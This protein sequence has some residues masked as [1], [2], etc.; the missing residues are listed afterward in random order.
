M[1]MR[2][3]TPFPLRMPDNLR[4]VIEQKAKE[5]GRS[6]NAELVIRIDSTIKT[7][8]TIRQKLNLHKIQNPAIAELEAIKEQIEQAIERLKEHG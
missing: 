6:V 2:S 3:Q 5:N 4:D 1:T 8:D 7:A